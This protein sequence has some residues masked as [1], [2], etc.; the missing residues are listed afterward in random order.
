[1]SDNRRAAHRR[2][3]LVA[4]TVMVFAVAVFV[5]P[6]DLLPDIDP[7]AG[8]V[9]LQ[10]LIHVGVSA[11]VVALWGWALPGVSLPALLA[12][13]ILF[14]GVAETAQTLPFVERS[15]KLEDFGYNVAGILAGVALVAVLRR[16]GAPRQRGPNRRG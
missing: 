3:I 14:A 10:M 7:D 12:L 1:M 9:P 2:R 15:A 4:A 13:G 11:A 8:V 5:V 16:R 6:L